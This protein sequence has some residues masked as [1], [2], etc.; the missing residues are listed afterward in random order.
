MSRPITW[1]ATGAVAVVAAALV[2]VG[3]ALAASHATK[4]LITGFTPRSAKPAQTVMVKGE[5]FTAVKSVTLD[6]KAVSY[7][8]DSSKEI[9]I[10]IASGD[11]TGKIEVKTAGGTAMSKHPLTIT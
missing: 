5:R 11:K 9:T 4:P 7:K 6:G 3:A 2:L 8:V 1:R 10:T